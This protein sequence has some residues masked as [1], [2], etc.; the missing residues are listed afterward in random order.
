MDGAGPNPDEESI[1]DLVGRLIEDGRDYA[2][3][4]LDHYKAIAQHRAG[5]ARAAAILLGIGAYLGLLIGVALVVGAVASLAR[6][7]DP[8]LAGLVVAVVLAIPAALL[9]RAGA[10]G[11]AALGGDEDEKEAIRR[12]ED[13]R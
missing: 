4:E 8:A 10:R 6:L 11:M 5:R 12:G 2:K 3:A 7:M 1:G 9:I 13:G